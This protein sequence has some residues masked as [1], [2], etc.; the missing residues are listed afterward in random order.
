MVPSRVEAASLLLSL[1]PPAWHL[2]HSRAVAEIAG[3]LAARIERRGGRQA[4]DRSLVE[5]AALLHDVDKATPRAERLPG[6]HGE[7]GAAWLGRRGYP[8][9]GEAVACHP[10]TLLVDDA[11]ASRVL[12]APIEAK[13]VAY[14]D[15]RAGQRL[16]AMAERFGRWRRRHPHSRGSD[17]WSP[18]V[19]DAAWRHARR[20]EDE[21]CQLAGCRPEDVARLR[22][23][24]A[25]LAAARGRP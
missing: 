15:K 6:P 4:V 12:H 25:A 8:E 16:E 14:A 22:W 9:L 5:A 18:E 11:H 1:A 10:V 19:A 17:G 23:T 2:R 24:S 20:I 3:W 7:A 21:V 13:L